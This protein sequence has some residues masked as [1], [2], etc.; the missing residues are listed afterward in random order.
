M[1][2][3][4]KHFL[5]KIIWLSFKIYFSFY[6]INLDIWTL[7]VRGRTKL[8][9][10]ILSSHFGTIGWTFFFLQKCYQNWKKYFADFRNIFF[11]HFLYIELCARPCTPQARSSSLHGPCTEFYASQMNTKYVSEVFL[12][13]IVG[14]K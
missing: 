13:N 6:M 10:R 12:S 9:F 3:F 2:I 11:I 7:Q 5:K 14:K 4:V 1:I 8:N